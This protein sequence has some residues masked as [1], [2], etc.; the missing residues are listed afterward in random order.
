MQ[1]LVDINTTD[2]KPALERLIKCLANIQLWFLHSSLQLNANCKSEAILLG[3]MHQ[4]WSPAGTSVIN[5]SG[6]NVPFAS[7]LRLDSH[8]REVATA[9]N[10][11]TYTL[12]HVCS[13]LTDDMPKTVACSIVASKLHCC[14]TL[15]Y[16][17]PMA[18]FDILQRVQN[19]LASHLPAQWT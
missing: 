4:L 9:C 3:T 17:A 5:V 10:I 8:A 18:T 2:F 16:G 12:R 1:L 15:L 6:A 19:N 11:H 14:N 13:L 7:H